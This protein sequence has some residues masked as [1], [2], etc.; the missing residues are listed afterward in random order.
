MRPGT[1]NCKPHP[2]L[3]LAHIRTGV[4]G[5]SHACVLRIGALRTTAPIAPHTAVRI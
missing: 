1:G 5:N 2:T 4:A 3:L